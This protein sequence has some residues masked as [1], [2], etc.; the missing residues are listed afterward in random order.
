MSWECL[1]CLRSLNTY[2]HLINIYRAPDCSIQTQ[3]H[4]NVS[5]SHVC[6]CLQ[7]MFCSLMDDPRPI[8][9]ITPHRKSAPGGQHQFISKVIFRGK[10]FA[11]AS[12]ERSQGGNFL[13]HVSVQR[14]PRS[15]RSRGWRDW[16]RMRPHHWGVMPSYWTH[17]S[18]AWLFSLWMFL[19]SPAEHQTQQKKKKISAF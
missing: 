3:A 4:V 14:L 17:S 2:S 8:N 7:S 9:T 5:R 18:H 13:C 15:G 1:R 19:H 11:T 12:F 10:Y 6:V 16:D